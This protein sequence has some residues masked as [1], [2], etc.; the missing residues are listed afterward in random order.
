MYLKKSANISKCLLF[1]GL[2]FVAV[3]LWAHFNWIAPMKHKVKVGETAFFSLNHGHEFPVGEETPNTDYIKAFVVA[4]S[5]EKLELS[6][7]MQEESLIVSFPVKE[8]GRHIVYFEDDRGIRSRTP[9]GWQPGGKDKYPEASL[10]MKYYS[11]SLVYLQVGEDKN[12]EGILPLGLPFELTGSIQNNTLNA[13]VYK[14]KEP[15]EGIEVSLVSENAE[16]KVIGKTDKSG[17]INYDLNNI[18]GR[19]LLI[20]SYLNKMSPESNYDENRAASTL[21]LWIE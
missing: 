2:F 3:S 10:S 16:P 7:K 13:A 1:I 12:E 17:K 4:A 21:Y 5:G 19:L 20:T 14:N 6:P 8:T 15:M 18:H 9:R 11:S